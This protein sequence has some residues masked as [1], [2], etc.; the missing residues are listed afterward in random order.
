MNVSVHSTEGF[1]SSVGPV[2]AKPDIVPVTTKKL[3]RSDL[4]IKHAYQWVS[5]C[6]PIYTILVD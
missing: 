1:P 4:A 5:T 2:N 3:Q 6:E